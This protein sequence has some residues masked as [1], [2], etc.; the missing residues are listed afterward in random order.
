[1][2]AWELPTS[3]EIGGVGRPIRTDY[4][5]V[6]DAL[7]YMTD[8]D[9]DAEERAMIFLRILYETFDE[10]PPQLYEE[11]LQKARDFIDAGIPRDEKPEFRPATMDWDQDAGL[12]VPAVNHVLGTEVRAVPYLHWWTFLG[13]YMEI[14]DGLFSAVLNIRNKRAKGKTLE[15]HELEFYRENHAIVDMRGR[16]TEERKAQK[17]RLKKLRGK[18]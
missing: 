4:R 9:Y 11:A 18:G 10:L 12:I 8:P 2:N 14:K 6:L 5:A 7:R 3:L 16:E 15:K 17:E 13:A 1:M